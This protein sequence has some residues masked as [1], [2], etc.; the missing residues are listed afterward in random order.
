MSRRGLCG[1]I[2]RSRPKSASLLAITRRD[3]QSP[4]AAQKAQAQD[5]R[6]VH[7]PTLFL[8]RNVSRYNTGRQRSTAP[9]ILLISDRHAIRR[10]DRFRGAAGRPSLRKF[11]TF[12]PITRCDLQNFVLPK[13]CVS[14]KSTRRRFSSAF[15]R[16][17]RPAA[18][19]KRLL[20]R[21]ACRM[22]AP[23]SL[24]LDRTGIGVLAIIAT[25][26]RP[27]Y[28]AHQRTA[29]NVMRT[30]GKFLNVRSVTD[31]HAGL[32]PLEAV[33]ALRGPVRREQVAHRGR[34]RRRR[35]SNFLAQ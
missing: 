11:A 35:L 33:V 10:S 32:I 24:A 14:G 29:A 34:A 22:P 19:R 6:N 17:G 20:R 25:I 15:R 13:K 23:A 18:P 16:E 31:A 27:E 9:I 3:R 2:H 5:P 21:I 1:A 12:W 26:R 28:R 30:A 8:A 4:F 7:F